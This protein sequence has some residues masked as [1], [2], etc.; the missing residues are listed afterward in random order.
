[1]TDIQTRTLGDIVAG[2]PATAPTLDRLGLDYCCH[3]QRSL[4]SACAEAGLD[5]AAVL[6]ELAAIDPGGDTSWAGLDP[7]A[8]AGHIV[9]SHHRYLKEELP[10]LDGLA[11]KVLAVH[12]ERHPELDEVRALVRE[13]RADMEPH[14]MKEERILF[15]AI[16]ELAR[17]RR[18]FPFGSVGNPIRMMLLEHDRAGELLA[19]LRSA[20]GGYA[21][22]ADACAS[23]RSLYER[24]EALEADTH[25]HVHKENHTLF[26]AAL[27]L[28]E[29]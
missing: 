19:A 13:I 26:P 23:Y 27:R 28:A 10:L 2:N 8:L 18:D 11:E 20:T 5:P 17:G 15:P 6:A 14:L 3:G 29:G 12:G 4:E 1:M 22:P 7:S 24:L 21:V 16:E 25:L 9:A